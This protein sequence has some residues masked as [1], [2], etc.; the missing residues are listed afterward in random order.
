MNEVR[1]DSSKRIESAQEET[2]LIKEK[3]TLEIRRLE[4]AILEQM[5]SQIQSHTKVEPT[6]EAVSEPTSNKA[7]KESVKVTLTDDASGDPPQECNGWL[8]KKGGGY[9]EK[10]HESPNWPSGR[11]NWTKRYFSLKEGRIKYYNEASMEKELY[12]GDLRSAEVNSAGGLSVSALTDLKGRRQ[13]LLNLKDRSLRLC[14]PSEITSERSESLMKW[15]KRSLESHH[16]FYVHQQPG[17][18][19]ESTFVPV[20]EHLPQDDET[21]SKRELNTLKEIKKN[22]AADLEKR[23]EELKDLKESLLLQEENTTKA[24]QKLTIAEGEADNLRVKMSTKDE[25]FRRREDAKSRQEEKLGQALA[26]VSAAEEK[27][28]RLKEG[29]IKLN[30][31]DTDAVLLKDLCE[32]LNT[33]SSDFSNLLMQDH[34]ILKENEV[35]L[36]QELEVTKASLVLLKNVEAEAKNEM[37]VMRKRITGGEIAVTQLNLES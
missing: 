9:S 19:I 27:A 31:D 5:Q 1:E 17:V 30:A 10:T 21:V 14:V 11:T 32:I 29:V 26:R 25:L 37:I 12:V 3:A 28:A 18:K 22:L 7:H 16:K 8:M 13:L 6:R 34:K 2:R 15:W 4:K 33:A 23:T 36:K 35:Q 24:L 20:A